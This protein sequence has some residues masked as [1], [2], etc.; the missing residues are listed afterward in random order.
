MGWRIAALV[1]VLFAGS[2]LFGLLVAAVIAAGRGP[3][4][5]GD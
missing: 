4:K 3:R 1:L 5:P 2:A